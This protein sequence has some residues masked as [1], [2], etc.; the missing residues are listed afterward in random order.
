M[1]HILLVQT[2][3]NCA[4][5]RDKRTATTAK[6]GDVALDSNVCVSKVLAKLEAVSV[7][8][9]APQIHQT[10]PQRASVPWNR[11]LCPQPCTVVFVETAKDCQLQNSFF[12]IERTHFSVSS[13]PAVVWSPYC[14]VTPLKPRS[15]GTAST[16]EGCRASEAHWQSHRRM[17]SDGGPVESASSIH[18]GASLRLWIFRQ[19]QLVRQVCK[20]PTFS[21]AFSG[22]SSATRLWPSGCSGGCAGAGLQAFPIW[23]AAT[24]TH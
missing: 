14:K 21:S 19:Q 3:W 11:R 22:G 1:L 17:K 9:H 18:L 2:L 13:D 5:S 16:L 24:S 10:A 6:H 20:L 7:V 8:R 4:P 12:F 15:C 23:I